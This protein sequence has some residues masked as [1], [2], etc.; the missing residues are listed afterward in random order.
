MCGSTTETKL[1]WEPTHRDCFLEFKLV[2]F[3]ETNKDLIEIL[4]NIYHVCGGDW[5]DYQDDET[6]RNVYDKS[7]PTDFEEIVTPFEVEKNGD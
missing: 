7:L 4:E 3:S 1:L 5:R 2:G 6:E